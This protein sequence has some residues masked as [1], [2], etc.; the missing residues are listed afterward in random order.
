MLLSLSAAQ[1]SGDGAVVRALPLF[2]PG[3]GELMSEIPIESE[4]IGE[5]MSEIVDALVILIT[6]GL[7]IEMMSGMRRV[8]GR[9]PQFSSVHA[10]R[11]ASKR[12]SEGDG[13]KHVVVDLCLRRRRRAT[14]KA[15]GSAV[16]GVSEWPRKEECCE[17]S[18]QSAVPGRLQVY[19]ARKFTLVAAVTC[20][21]FSKDPSVA[22][23]GGYSYNCPPPV[24]CFCSSPSHRLSFSFRHK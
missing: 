7:S 9:M 19:A 12:A 2:V 14:L 16:G 6:N 22:G 15:A 24:L 10:G 1:S 13:A 20:K 4:I 17:Q 18:S 23:K 8:L 5:I 21:S 3:A 11:R